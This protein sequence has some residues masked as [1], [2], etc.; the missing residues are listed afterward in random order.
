MTN[1]IAQETVEKETN[2]EVVEEVQIDRSELLRSKLEHDLLKYF[3]NKEIVKER[4]EE[5]KL[6]FENIESYFEALPETE[7]IL[8]LPNG[9]WS[10]LHNRTTLKEV[11]DKETLA[12]NLGIDKN[13]L[14]TPWD[15]SKLAEKFLKE[16]E[17]EERE[18]KMSELISDHTTTVPV[19]KLKLSKSK[20]KPKEK[21]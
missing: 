3:Q 17:Q 19:T 11:L 21:K 14:K 10:K 15:F 1:E 18:T 5:N 8:Q 16:I 20:N 7:V 13:E 9:E 2:I 6:L 4:N 12:F